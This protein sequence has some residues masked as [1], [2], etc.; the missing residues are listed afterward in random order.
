M[1]SL[2]YI[3]TALLIIVASSA[4]SSV[5]AGE[6]D[7]IG[8]EAHPKIPANSTV[9]I[10]IEPSSLGAGVNANDVV[11]EAANTL[12]GK[13]DGIKFNIAPEEGDRPS[14]L[15][16]LVN[17]ASPVEARVAYYSGSP[18][19]PGGP[20]YAGTVTLYLGET[21]CDTPA[22]RLCF[23]PSQP[24]AYRNALY[25]VLVHELI[26]ALNGSD[27]A[28]DGANIMSAFIGVNSSKNQAWGVDCI[29]NKLP[30]LRGSVPPT[31]S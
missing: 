23:D 6:C 29:V 10:V 2:K 1:K 24:A 4:V 11:G 18:Q 8:F 9:D 14:I 16:K 19:T 22:T 31:C 12:S 13:V 15:I 7:D 25:R 26:H 17:Q 21:G 27:S 30:S 20:L 3:R 5:V 28:K